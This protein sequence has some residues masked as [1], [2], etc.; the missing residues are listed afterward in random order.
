MDYKNI[1]DN[2]C[3]FLVHEGNEDSKTLLISKY[4]PLIDKISSYNM[5]YASSCGVDKS[6]LIQEGTIGLISA[7][8]SFD[9]KKN[10]TFYTYASV[11]I[12]TNIR[13]YIRSAKRNKN[14]FLNESL[15]LDNNILDDNVSLYE[16]FNDNN[17][18]PSKKVEEKEYATY[19][20]DELKKSLTAYEQEVFNLKLKNMTNTEIAEILN[21]D[22]RSIE[23]TLVRIKNKYKVCIR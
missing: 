10:V 1:N 20:I 19:L 4:K 17:S 21:K 18:D 7:M 3:L 6:D 9:K 8:K 2:E 14:K 22:K 15:S 16:V 5:L 12:E 11:C 13:Q 23:N